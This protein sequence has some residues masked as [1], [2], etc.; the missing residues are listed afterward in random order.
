MSPLSN[1]SFGFIIAYA[2]PGLI[3]LWSLRDLSPMISYWLYA[4]GEQTKFQPA[5]GGV[6]YSSI[7]ALGLGMAASA[8]RFTLLDPL[9]AHTGLKRPDWDDTKLQENLDAFQTA[10]D[11]HYRY[12]QFHAN[13]TVAILWA[14]ALHRVEQG[15]STSPLTTELA[16]AILC[17][18]F[19]RTA[20]DNLKKYYTRTA[21]ILQSQETNP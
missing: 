20:R 6:L 4:S 17:A 11:Y 10:I 19:M 12:Y 3:I 18:V 1:R 21:V 13:T 7:A 16:V 2:I 8:I 9:M 15:F 14:Y 5:I